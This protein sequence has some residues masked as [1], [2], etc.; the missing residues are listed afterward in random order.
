MAERR[1][2]VAWLT[3]NSVCHNAA[4]VALSVGDLKH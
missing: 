3:A 1:K 2:F 4:G